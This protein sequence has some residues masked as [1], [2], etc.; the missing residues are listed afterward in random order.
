MT[1]PQPIGGDN[2]EVWLAPTP[3][4]ALVKVLGL[5]DINY[6][7]GQ[8]FAEAHGMDAAHGFD[9]PVKSKPSIKAKRIVDFDDPTVFE[10]LGLT[11]SGQLSLFVYYPDGERGNRSDGVA[12]SCWVKTNQS[13]SLKDAVGGDIEFIPALGDWARFGLLAGE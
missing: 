4:E 11:E 6:E 13:Q 10:C 9:V 7:P 1:S 8:N 12:G 2:G 5:Q 3:G